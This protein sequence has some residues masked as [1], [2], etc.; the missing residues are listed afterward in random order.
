MG[1]NQTIPGSTDQDFLVIVL[2]MWYSIYLTPRQPRR[3]ILEKLEK[4]K[5]KKKKK[6]EFTTEYRL[7]K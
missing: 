2:L 6:K 4:K 7:K 3:T 1:E 5:K